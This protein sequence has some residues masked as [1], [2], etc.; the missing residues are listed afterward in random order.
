MGNKLPFQRIYYGQLFAAQ[1]DRIK[2]AARN[3][4]NALV[5]YD[6]DKCIIYC[7]SSLKCVI[8]FVYTK[9]STLLSN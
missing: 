7:Q 6:Y 1:I 4:N 2:V 9:L 3:T 5:I 8:I